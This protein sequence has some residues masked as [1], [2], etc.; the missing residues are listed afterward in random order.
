MKKIIPFL[1]VC[2]LLLAV[3]VSCNNNPGS[4]GG[5]VK[6]PATLTVG[7]YREYY[8]VGALVREIKGT[9]Y[10]TDSDG[11]ITT[12]NFQDEGVTITGFDST[13]PVEKKSMTVSY[14]GIDCVVTY[15]IASIEKV[16]IEGTYVFEKN[17]TYEF[18][19]DSNEIT[20]EVWSSWDDF[21]NCGTEGKKDPV[22]S[23][24]SYTREINTSGKTVIK[25]EG[26]SWPYHPDG[27]GGIEGKPNAYD[28]GDYMPDTCFYV[29]TEKEDTRMV[30]NPNAQGKY[31]VC[32]FNFYG[33]M[34][35]WFTENVDAGTLATL[36]AGNGIKVEAKYFCFNTVGVEM[37]RSTVTGQEAKASNLRLTIKDGY[38]SA[39]RAF[40]IV[41]EA[42]TTAE[43]K[44]YGYNYIMKLTAIEPSSPL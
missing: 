22:V 12:L 25:I 17:T 26:D 18:K 2:V 31:L 40:S 5:D 37:Q 36:N 7:N 33:D 32:A 27:R 11:K 41:S 1:M 38:T 39:T 8:E 28:Y 16:E 9:L 15:S 4:K 10:Y 29:S 42:D 44:Y 34:Y 30:T 43:P 14:K 21:Y 24:L 20:K 35:M 19:K 6:R 23:K 13:V 3:A